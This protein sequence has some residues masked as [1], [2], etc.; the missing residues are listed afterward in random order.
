MPI[1]HSDITKTEDIVSQLLQLLKVKLHAE[2][3]ADTEGIK[4]NL[5]GQD[6]AI[7]I[8]YHGETLA[9]LAFLIGV[10]L[11]RQLDKDAT[12][13]VDAGDY[14]KGKDRR[15]KEMAKKAIAKVKASGSPETLEGLNSYERRIVHAEA[16]AEGLDSASEGEGKERKI[17]IK[18]N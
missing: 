14:L 7:I 3:S 8:G 2:V 15:I 9:D 12:V 16:S 5:R 4:V 6:S 18:S 10:I 1:T 11:R 13:R 17:V